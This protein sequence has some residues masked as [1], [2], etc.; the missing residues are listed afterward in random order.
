MTGVR[1][2]NT[3]SVVM[4]PL[5][6]C[7]ARCRYCFVP[8]GGP[9]RRMSL[10]EVEH[11]FGELLLTMTERGYTRL[12]LYWQGGEILL[13]EPAWFVGMA[14]LARRLF[15]PHG[16]HVEQHLQSNLLL[17]GPAWTSVIRDVFGG[18][19]GTSLDVPNLHRCA[20]GA[21]VD[22]YE[23]VWL[24]RYR[25][26]LADGL[27]ASPICVPNRGT[28][29]MGPARFYHHFVVE[30]GIRRFQI[31]YPFPP[32]K[33]T[34]WYLP[35]QELGAFMVGLLEV[36]LAD[37]ATSGVSI[38]P[39]AALLACFETGER[40]GV[41]CV[42]GVNCAQHFLSIG[43]DGDVSLCDYW[44]ASQPDHTFGNVYRTPLSEILGAGVRNRFVA[45][46]RALLQGRC[47]L[48]P[49]LSLCHGGCPTRS[50]DE[51]GAYAGPEQ[52]CETHLAVFQ[53]MESTVRGGAEEAPRAVP[54]DPAGEGAA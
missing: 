37:R 43:A 3:L 18:R 30:L 12:D 16:I 39:L 2:G 41:P 46:T 45:R 44:V 27:E 5:T 22:R 11:I 24:E 13:L 23:D 31:N 42:Y 21:P 19:V 48:C 47:G 34:G 51:T 40:R 38:S 8:F 49:Y 29:E 17:Y 26:L 20:A 35:P 9:P 52:Y 33:A 36:W 4:L 7:N 10:D 54:P 50:R 1:R 15:E 25:Q 32:P 28:L 53:A 14:A 6:E